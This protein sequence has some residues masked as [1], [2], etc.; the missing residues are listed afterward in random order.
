MN[1][2]DVSNPRP[3]RSQQ[4]NSLMATDALQSLSDAQL[5]EV[6]TAHLEARPMDPIALENLGNKLSFMGHMK[7]R[8]R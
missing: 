1:T 2:L 6:L 8:A 3:T 5:I 7:A 4:N